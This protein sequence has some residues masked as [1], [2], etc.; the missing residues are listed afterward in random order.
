VTESLVWLKSQEV[1]GA[2][3]AVTVRSTDSVLP[4]LP[5]NLV[6]CCRYVRVFFAATQQ[7]FFLGLSSTPHV[8]AVALSV[9]KGHR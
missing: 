7:R 1:E 5:V 4:A 9:P 2:V 6:F 8:R 3:K